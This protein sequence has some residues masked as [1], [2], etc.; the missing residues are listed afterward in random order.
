MFYTVSMCRSLKVWGSRVPLVALSLILSLTGCSTPDPI[1]ISMN[2][3]DN[4]VAGK[5]YGIIKVIEFREHYLEFDPQTQ[6]RQWWEDRDMATPI[7][8]IGSAIRL[9]KAA[10]GLVIS[11]DTGQFE[12]PA[13]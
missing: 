10:G 9:A 5:R 2:E 12:L 8:D 13:P 11:L 4:Q 6:K 1:G 3:D 7:R